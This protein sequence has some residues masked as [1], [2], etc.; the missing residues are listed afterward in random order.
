[1]IIILMNYLERPMFHVALDS[2]IIKA[3]SNQPFSIK[4]GVDRIHSHLIFGCISN[5]PLSIIE[6]N[7]RG[8]GSVSLI[9]GNDFNFTMLKNSNTGVGGTQIYTNSQR[10]LSHLFNFVSHELL[11]LGQL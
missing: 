10:L 2:S 4:N 11:N 6:S 9:I 3:P 5:Q 1:M 7:I 8:S